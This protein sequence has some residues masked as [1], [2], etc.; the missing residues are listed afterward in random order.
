[1]N[2]FIIGIGVHSAATAL[3]NLRL[4][5]IGYKTARSALDNAGISQK[6]IDHVTLA[7][8][9]ELDG[10]SI[11][12]MVMAVPSGAYL[13]D[14]MRVTDSGLSGLQ[15]GAMRIASGDLDIG[16]VVSWNQT[17]IGP[18]ENIALMRAEPFYTRPIG[19]NFS[20]SDGLFANAYSQKY[21]I[22]D[23]TAAQRVMGRLED[24]RK[25]TRAVINAPMTID[26]ILN[27]KTVSHPLRVGH[28]APVTDGAVAMVLAS[29]NWLKANPHV[30]PL[31]RI[32]GSSWAVDRFQFDAQRLAGMGLFRDCLADV[33]NRAEISSIEKIDVI[34]MEA[35]TAWYDIA[36]TQALGSPANTRINPSGGAW[37]QN[38][39]FCTGLLNSAEAVW[40]VSGR[41]GNHQVK[42]AKY[43]MAHGTWGFAQQAHGFMVFEGVHQ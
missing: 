11:S 29:G 26:D 33:L 28:R 15:L 39:F 32:A 35:Q 27:S 7:A 23:L 30:K 19:L 12:S 40:Q 42:G 34:E 38:P 3:N 5:E 41:A 16:L 2:V 13:K 8:C 20:I 18:M 4:E 24:A 10:R 25:N 9:D 31:A 1:M 14:E 43:A 37:A 17:S 6:E 22:D 36:F 21:G